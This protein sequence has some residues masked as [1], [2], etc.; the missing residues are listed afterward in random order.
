YMAI[1]AYN[2]S[3]CATKF[4]I[5]FLCLRIFD[6]AIW[7]RIIYAIL[8]LLGV[9]TIWVII[10]SIAPCVPISSQWDKTVTGWCFPRL[11]MWILNAAFNI[12]TDFCIVTLPI[13]AI[14]TLQLPRR[15]KIGVSLI[16]ALGFFICVI[17]ILRIPSLLKAGKSTD[18]T[19]DNCG[20]ANWSVIE[21]NAAIVGACLSTL[22][23]LLTRMWP[24]FLSSVQNTNT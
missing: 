16:F 6:V 9:Y 1:I 22:K 17:S 4:S 10:Y 12:I 8:V 13:P 23:P 11:Q 3:L 5:M 21:V 24:G 7:R 19:N 18:P 14:M 20:I 2:A 15:Q